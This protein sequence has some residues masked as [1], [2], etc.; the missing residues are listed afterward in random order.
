LAGLYGRVLHP[1]NFGT[2]GFGLKKR[3]GCINLVCRNGVHKRTAEKKETNS[4]KKKH[5]QDRRTY[6]WGTEFPEGRRDP[7]LG[8]Y[9]VH[10]GVNPT[11][12]SL[13]RLLCNWY[14]QKGDRL[15]KEKDRGRKKKKR[16]NNILTP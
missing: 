3:G 9:I 8:G 1:H 7:N 16:V 6:I 2:K 10:L 13:A 5:S 11:P 12:T 14:S 15:K 4:L